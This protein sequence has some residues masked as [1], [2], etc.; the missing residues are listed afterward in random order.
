MCRCRLCL[1]VV[2]QLGGTPWVQLRALAKHLDNHLKSNPQPNMLGFNDVKNLAG[3]IRSAESSKSHEASKDVPTN[4]GKRERVSKE[5]RNLMVWLTGAV[6]NVAESLKQP[7]KEDSTFYG[8]LYAAVMGV[9]G[10]TEEALMYMPC[11]TF[12]ITSPNVTH[13]C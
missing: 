7:V 6:N 4:L 10:F 5:D 8:D 12:L 1:V 2:W 11:H 13:S 9:P 3:H